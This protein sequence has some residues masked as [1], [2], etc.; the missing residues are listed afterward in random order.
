MLS[1]T[2]LQSLLALA[3]V[4]DDA[5]AQNAALPPHRR[6]QLTQ[7]SQRL[8]AGDT[9]AIDDLL[10]CTKP[11]SYASSDP[12]LSSAE[13]ERLRVEVERLRAAQPVPS[14]VTAANAARPATPRDAETALREARAWL[15]AGDPN[16][17]LKALPPGGGGDGGDGEALYRKA[18][19]LERLDRDEEALDAYRRVAADTTSPLLKLSA[20]SGVDHIE[21]RMRR[22]RTPETK[23]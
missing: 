9:S 10:A 18:C 8:I 15:R 2:L 13:I 12:A 20:A 1:N 16:H 19:A 3:A 11:A 5:A 17:C 14:A 22:A 7:L 4:A 6:D 21:W 23:P